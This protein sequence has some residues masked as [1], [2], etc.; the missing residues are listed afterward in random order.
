MYRHEQDER[1]K[2]AHP[3]CTTLPVQSVFQHNMNEYLE[4]RK[5]D[6]VLARANGW[7]ESCEAGDSFPRVVI[8]AQTWKAGHV[9]YQARDTTGKAYLRY[10]SPKGP[11]HDALIITTPK[12]KSLGQVIVEGPMCAL[13]A[14]M[15]GYIGVALM[16]MCPSQSTLFHLALLLE[17]EMATVVLLD[18]DSGA[19]SVKVTMFLAAQGFCVRSNQF[20]KSKDLAALSVKESRKLLERCFDSFD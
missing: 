5:L 13:R 11:R 16:G 14:A 18:R 15:C 8:P 9:Y 1:K 2:S 17:E 20:T 4:S 10:Q 19:A 6:W 3:M 7:F 12:G